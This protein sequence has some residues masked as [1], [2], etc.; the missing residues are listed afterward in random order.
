MTPNYFFIFIFLPEVVANPYID[1]SEPFE[2]KFTIEDLLDFPEYLQQ[3]YDKVFLSAAFPYDMSRLTIRKSQKEEETFQIIEFAPREEEDQLY[4]VKAVVHTVFDESNYYTVEERADRPGKYLLCHPMHDRHPILHQSWNHIPTDEELIEAVSSLRLDFEKLTSHIDMLKANY[5]QAT[6]LY[7]EF[8]ECQKRSADDND[9]DE[10]LRGCADFSAF[11][12]LEMLDDEISRKQSFLQKKL[13]ECNGG[14]LTAEQKYKRLEAQ[15]T[16]VELP[17]PIASRFDRVFRFGSVEPPLFVCE[18][19]HRKGIVNL[20]GREI[21]P[22]QQYEIYEQID[23]DG[24]I[25]FLSNGK[26]GLCHFGVCTN[27]IFDE[28][29]IHS[30]EYCQVVLQGQKGWVDSEGMFTQNPEEAYFGSWYDAD[31]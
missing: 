7:R 12:A 26:W 22:C 16:R 6:A 11:N 9:D 29:I 27:A 2:Q 23:N 3:A 1:K 21:I 28:V 24:V 4:A 14:M 19:N 8:C 15:Y 20:K 18:R 13:Q 5:K 17:E 10:F 30:E 25:P 31:K